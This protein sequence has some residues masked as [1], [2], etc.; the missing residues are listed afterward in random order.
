MPASVRTHSGKPSR[1]LVEALS[2]L[3]RLTEALAAA[4]TPAMVKPE[5]DQ[6]DGYTRAAWTVART[7]AR[8]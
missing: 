2:E 8:R 1:W 4:L 3:E 7:T 6:P 5:A